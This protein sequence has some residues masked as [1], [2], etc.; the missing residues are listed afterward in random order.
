MHK[1]AWGSLQPPLLATVSHG[2]LGYDKPCIWGAT[3]LHTCGSGRH[4]PFRRRMCRLLDM[5]P[6]FALAALGAHYVVLTGALPVIGAF[7]VITRGGARGGSPGHR[8]F[9]GLRMVLTGAL[10]VIA[11]I[12]RT[13]DFFHHVHSYTS[14]HQADA[15][16]TMVTELPRGALLVLAD[17]SMNYTH[18]HQD[19]AQQVWCALSIALTWGVRALCTAHVS[20]SV[21]ACTTRKQRV[22]GAR[23]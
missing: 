21:V 5:D 13:D 10:S 7:P 22:R 3:C 14:R 1:P 20:A 16:N 4:V 17:F 15:F 19:A 8:G 2:R 18:K 6:A 11:N 12:G 23:K 9:P